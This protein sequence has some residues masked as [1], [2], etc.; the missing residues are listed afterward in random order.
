MIYTVFFIITSE[1]AFEGNSIL[2]LVIDFK[3]NTSKPYNNKARSHVPR[4][5]CLL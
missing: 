4:D 3:A 5:H 2:F 1:F